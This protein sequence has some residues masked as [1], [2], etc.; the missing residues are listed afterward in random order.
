MIDN[1]NKYDI[2]LM[3]IGAIDIICIHGSH[4]QIKKLGV[5][6]FF[7]ALRVLRIFKIAKVWK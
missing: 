5:Q 7:R 1:H 6:T 2:V 3:I 4:N